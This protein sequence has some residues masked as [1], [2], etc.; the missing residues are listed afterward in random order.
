MSAL[1]IV[2][3]I[4]KQ[5][6]EKWGKKK[7]N[8]ETR[9]V[10]SLDGNFK[11]TSHAH[12]HDRANVEMHNNFIAHLARKFE[13]DGK[14]HEKESACTNESGISPRVS[15]LGEKKMFSKQAIHA[16]R[17]CYMYI[18]ISFYARGVG[19]A[20]GTCA[21]HKNQHARATEALYII[22]YTCIYTKRKM[23]ALEFF[24]PNDKAWMTLHKCKMQVGRQN[25]II[26]L[27]QLDFSF[28][29]LMDQSSVNKST[30]WRKKKRKKTCQDI[31]FFVYPTFRLFRNVECYFVRF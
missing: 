16:L 5:K 18:L 14:K 24:D 4:K 17:L 19:I 21:R 10:L 8:F 13:T 30:R 25:I 26:Q 7:T 12:L 1:R 11:W 22:T 9:R 20:S 3:E 6:R 15:N 29:F 2:K 27:F 31:I 23:C 28:D